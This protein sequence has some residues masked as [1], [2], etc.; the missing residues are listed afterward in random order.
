MFLFLFPDAD[1]VFVNIDYRR[2]IEHRTD[3]AE[4]LLEIWGRAMLRE[5]L[6]VQILLIKEEF[7]WFFLRAMKSIDKSIFFRLHFG[8]Y[9]FQGFFQ[10]LLHSRLCFHYRNHDQHYCLLYWYF[11]NSIS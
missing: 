6:L 7:T 10:F 3:L 9:F 5:R 4:K 11:A 2:A 1:Q 8:D